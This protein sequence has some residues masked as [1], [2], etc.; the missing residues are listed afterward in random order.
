MPTQNIRYIV[1]PRKLLI[2]GV[3]PGSPQYMTGIAIDAINKSRYIVGYKYTLDIIENIIDGTKQEVY[4]VTMQNQ[5]SIYQ[6]VYKKMEDGEYCAV[7]FTGDAN[8]SESEVIDRLLEIFGDD[9]VEVIPGISSIQ[10]ASAKSKIPLD[11]THVLS[12]HISDDIEKKKE[13]LINAIIDKKSVI[14][15][16]RPWP[17]DPSRNFMQ[18][19]IAKF[20][21]LNGIDTSLLKVWIFECLTHHNKET[22][23]RGKVI[24]LE[25][26]SFNPLSVM[27]IDQ[28][29]RQSYRKFIPQEQKQKM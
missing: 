12:F 24:D 17:N 22:V 11:K 21:R 18:S 28:N 20:L 9:N 2:V 10:V 23:F 7:P 8:F 6:A 14:M 25:G 13:E 27:V 29:R 3:G 19:D 4:Q 1:L 16:P 15:L 26:M 5:E